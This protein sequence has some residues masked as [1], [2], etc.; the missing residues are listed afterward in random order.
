M[1]VLVT[2]GAGYIGSHVARI[3][4]QSGTEV[5]V[6]DNYSTGLDSR[7]LGLPSTNLELSDEGATAALEQL[8]SQH[9]V[10][11]VVH[12]AALK[13][14]GE[15]VERPEEYFLKTWVLPPITKNAPRRH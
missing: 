10:T 11:A 6:V 2:G 7:V 9:K 5:Q 8:M 1:S 12:L 14:V 15:S 3:I 4:S 13:Q